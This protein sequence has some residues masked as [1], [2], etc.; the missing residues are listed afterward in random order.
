M[1]DYSNFALKNVAKAGSTSKPTAETVAVSFD[2]FESRLTIEMFNSESRY[3]KLV[4]QLNFK[5]FVVN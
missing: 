1:L 4:V 2:D 3:V 5:K